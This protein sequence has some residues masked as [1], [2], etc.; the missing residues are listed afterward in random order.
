MKGAIGLFALLLC[1]PCP[2]AGGKFVEKGNPV[3][4]VVRLLQDLSRKLEREAKE[5]QGLYDKFVCWGT[6]LT[7]EKTK[8][9]AD[10]KE[11]IEYLKTY[12]KDIDSGKVW[13]TNEREELE[14]EIQAVKSTMSENDETRHKDHDHFLEHAE[15]TEDGIDGLAVGVEALKASAGQSLL[16]LRGSSS[17]G[18]AMRTKRNSKLQVALKLG[19]AHLSRADA[20]F[21]KAVLTGQAKDEPLGPGNADVTGKYESRLGNVI[22]KLSDVSAELIVDLASDTK[23]DKEAQISFEERQK[24]KAAEKAAQEALLRK[25]KAEYAARDAAKA[26]SQEEIDALSEQIAANEKMIPDVE[27]ALKQKE[28]EW[29]Q[30][31]KYRAGEQE[32]IST[33]VELLHSDEARDLF[34]RSFIQITSI[35]KV[36]D[37][38]AR[39]ART[40]NQVLRSV[41]QYSN[42]GRLLVLATSLG[43]NPTMD[44]VLSKI[45]EMK[46]VIKKEEESD[47]AKKDDCE[48]TKVED[49]ATV[50]SHEAKIEDGS[51]TIG[52]LEDQIKNIKEDIA[53][54]NS[55]MQEVATDLAKAK[56]LRSAEND[57]Y[58]RSKKDDQDAVALI[59]KATKVIEDFYKSQKSF[60]QVKGVKGK[61]QLPDS[62]P[63]SFEGSYEGAGA[64]SSGVVQTMK[65]VSDDIEKEIAVADKEE[66][67]AKKVYDDAKKE[68][69]EKTV[70]LQDGID[71][72]NIKI[73]GRQDDLAAAKAELGD[74]KA[75]LAAVQQKMKD[76]EPE[77]N[78]YLENI[79]LRSKNRQIEIDGL[80]KAKAILQGAKFEDK[81]RELTV[82]DSF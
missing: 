58:L 55:T 1:S 78:F 61:R 44:N 74:N 60:I 33:A 54:K 8:E 77:C 27:T 72:D 23:A 68:M 71:S 47:L 9:V 80:D 81:G 70:L 79:E 42:D 69:D 53:K 26:E 52:F 20:A 10:A 66:A 16:S 22:Q 48:S 75:F 37:E 15:A 34:S 31:S 57:E 4:R 21:M 43:K 28:A 56:E 38:G 65:V 24:T 30:R 32:A 46:A 14:K 36:S 62:A 82:G 64:Q 18:A 3:S 63:K 45:D 73:G 29:D 40:A 13:F 59:E 5:E 49:T 25:L 2:A 6:T 7:T 12:I 17:A 67:E 41:A 35:S 39:R 50:K 76:A 19:E 51:T 11:R